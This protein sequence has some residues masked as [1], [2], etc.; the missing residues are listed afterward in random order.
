[1]QLNWLPWQSRIEIFVWCNWKSLKFGRIWSRNVWSWQVYSVHMC[2]ESGPKM[3]EMN[4]KKK[5]EV[6]NLFCQA[7]K[8]IFNEF[9]SSSSLAAY[10]SWNSY[11]QFD[12]HTHKY[13]LFNFIRNSGEKQRWKKFEIH[14]QRVHVNMCLCQSDMNHK[15]F[16]SCSPKVVV[17]VVVVAVFNIENI[18]ILNGKRNKNWTKNW[19][20]VCTC[21]FK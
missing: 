8:C 3:K 18:R 6:Q 4:A 10:Q 5:N 21:D 2:L 11:W 7:K 20:N 16:L 15:C 12:T 19:V 13:K 1:M 14:N 17:V 9:P